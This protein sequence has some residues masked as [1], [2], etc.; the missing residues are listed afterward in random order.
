MTSADTSGIAFY[1][2]YNEL[3]PSTISGIGV[4]HLDGAQLANCTSIFY[5]NLAS[6]HPDDDSEI[7]HSTT[8][9]PLTSLL[10]LLE[11][12]F[13]SEKVNN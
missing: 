7:W 13:Q 10:Y 6:Y 11:F 9:K 5:P 4:F 12:Q 8:A 3:V 1:Y 2:R